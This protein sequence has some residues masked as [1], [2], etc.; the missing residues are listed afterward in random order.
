VAAASLCSSCAHVRATHGK[1][2][3]TYLLCSNDEVPVKYAPQPVL[4]CPGYRPADPR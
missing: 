3:Q 2:G 1:R 4:R